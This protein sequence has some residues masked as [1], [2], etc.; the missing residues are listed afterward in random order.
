MNWDYRQCCLSLR[1]T[2]SQRMEK[3]ITLRRASAEDIPE[4]KALFRETVLNVNI[5]HYTADEVADWAACGEKPGHW[6]TLVNNLHFTIATNAQGSIVGFAAMR[7]DGYLHSLFV[8]KEWQGKGIARLLLEEAEA[9]ARKAGIVELTSEVS[10]TAR[11]FFERHG[12]VV[13]KSQRRKAM[14]L[15]LTNF[16][17]MKRLCPGRMADGLPKEQTARG[18]TMPKQDANAETGGNT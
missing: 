14:K 9:H 15:C 13:L 3:A 7:D 16:L 17:M 12:Y 18:N 10:I 11:P 8:H 1:T 2:T 4:I 5:K 6:E